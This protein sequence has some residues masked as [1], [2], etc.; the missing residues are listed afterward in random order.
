MDQVEQITAIAEAYFDGA[1]ASP[2]WDHTQRVYRLC[3][4]IGE[5]EGADLDVVR[6]AALLHDIA[7]SRE[8]QQNGKICPAREGARM[9]K[10]ILEE[11]PLESVKIEQ[12]VHCIEA[13]RF[14][15]ELKPK[16]LE[17]RVLFDADKLDSVGAVGIARAYLF[18]G[19]VGA[20]LHNQHP[21]P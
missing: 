5:Q 7:R 14:R 6:P 2:R 19:E 9:A 18:S 20:R 12:I 21:N 15:N 16:S 17:A 10:A 4:K 11:F 1:H 13:H 3:E 8:D